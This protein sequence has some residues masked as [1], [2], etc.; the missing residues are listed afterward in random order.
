MLKAVRTERG[1]RMVEVMS[2]G[3]VNVIKM[4][5]QAEGTRSPQVVDLFSMDVLQTL[6]HT[7]ART[8]L[9]FLVTSQC[10]EEGLALADASPHQRTH[11]PLLSGHLSMPGGGI[12]AGR[13]FTTPTHAPSSPFWS[14]LNAWRRDWRWQ[15]LHHTNARTLLSFLVT[16]QCLEE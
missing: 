12:G 6:H 2:E 11:P 10:L 16:S 9:S 5:Q 3:I 15:T 7:N 4:R 1:P 8:L 14:P 13:R